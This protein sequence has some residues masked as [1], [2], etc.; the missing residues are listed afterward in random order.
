MTP[1]CLELQDR[2]EYAVGNALVYNIPTEMIEAYRGRNVILRSS[3]P[4][5]IIYS[6]WRADLA[7]VCFIQLL[8]PSDDVAT[9][10]GSGEG[11]PIEIVLHDPGEYE[12][13]YNYTSLLDTHPVR[14]AIPAVRGFSKAVKLALSLDYAVK[15]E[16]EQPDNFV[17]L[18]LEAI[19]DVYLHRSHVRQPVEF[20]Q[21]MLMSFYRGDVVSLWEILEE[22]PRRVCYITD[23]GVETISRRFVGVNLDGDAMGFVQRLKTRL[24]DEK[25][26]CV[27][28]EFFDRCGG[29]FK[30][31]D[32]SYS[33]TGIK[34][35]FQTL[36]SATKEVRR[37]LASYDTAGVQV[38]P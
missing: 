32:Q 18:E 21:S 8:S 7:T 28:C 6:L 27:D 5:E 14:I 23:D 17:L 12:C 36:L 16:I 25:A 1:T 33:C 38:R 35:V 3:S 24:V 13:L 4:N 22:D 15:L 30:W 37:D 26:E 2:L 34:R 11:I 20:F 19:L 29:Y 10:E 9:L 31:P